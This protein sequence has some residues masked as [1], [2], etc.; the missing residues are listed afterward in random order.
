[1]LRKFIIK[2]LFHTLSVEKKLEIGVYVNEKIEALANV[3]YT[4]TG[5]KK[6]KSHKR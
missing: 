2:M 6:R 3:I 4:L 1:M 5:K